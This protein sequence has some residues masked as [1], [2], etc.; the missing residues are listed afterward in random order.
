ML[1]LGGRLRLGGGRP[2]GG[3]LLAGGGPL[4]G[5]ELLAGGGLPLCGNT[6]L[7]GDA[8]TDG[9]L[10]LGWDLL[11]G[12]GRR[13]FAGAD[14]DRWPVR[15][16]LQ[17]GWPPVRHSSRSAS[18]SAAPPHGRGCARTPAAAWAARRQHT[19]HRP[20]GRGPPSVEIRITLGD[21]SA[22]ARL[23]TGCTLAAHLTPSACPPV[24][25]PS[26]SASPSAAPPRG[27]RWRTDRGGTGRDAAHGRRVGQPTSHPSGRSPDHLTPRS[28]SP[29]RHLRA[30]RSCARAAGRRRPA[31]CGPAGYEPRATS[32][33]PRCPAGYELQVCGLQ[34]CGLR[35]AGTQDHQ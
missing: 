5:G 8:S 24:R 9:D 33:E 17:P 6:S 12:E 34:V 2:G 26:R 1:P 35:A 19:S 18:P 25:H 14:H 11:P 16:P 21:T 31:G 29:R 28:A 3:P 23:S 4:V 15:R 10:P 22:R 13:A 20:P 32:H 30:V 7:C 27:R